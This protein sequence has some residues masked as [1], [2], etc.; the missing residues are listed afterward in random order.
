MTVGLVAAE[1]KDLSGNGQ[2]GLIIQLQGSNL[3]NKEFL[4][5]VYPDELEAL[6][7]SLS[8]D[9]FETFCNQ[10]VYW[11]NDHPELPYGANVWTENGPVNLNALNATE[12]ERYGIDEVILSGDGYRILDRLKWHIRKGTSV[13]FFQSI[14]AGS[15]NITCNLNWQDA[16]SS[17]KFTIFAPDG[18]MGPYYDSS[19]GRTDGRIF[20][21]VSREATL[22]SGDWYVVIEP[23]KIDA[24]KTDG[25]QPFIVFFY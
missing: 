6:R 19:D 25:V 3:T 8:E 16:N 15:G 21:Q 1:K 14:P 18:M 5:T 10:K 23:E 22:S 11:G 4:E 13:A 2:T 20:L 9:A 12:K 7:Q 24:G 17:L